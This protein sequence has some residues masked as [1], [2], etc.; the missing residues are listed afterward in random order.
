MPEAAIAWGLCAPRSTPASRSREWVLRTDAGCEQ[1]L[2]D[3][4]VN[5]QVAPHCRRSRDRD[6][7]A[8]IDP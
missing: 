1:S 4:T 6:E 8:G 2:T 3:P 5:G 7:T